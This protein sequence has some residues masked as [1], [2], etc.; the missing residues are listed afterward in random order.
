MKFSQLSRYFEKIEQT[1]SR[2]EITRLLA[3]LFNKLT[4][5]E[6]DKTIYLL[7][8]RVVPLFEKIDFG[9]AERLIIKSSISALNVDRKLFDKRF[10]KEGD[11]GRTVEKFKK[12]FPSL[13]ETDFTINEVYKN[14]YSLA[15][16]SG[17]GSQE[18]KVS[19]LADLI[20][21]TDPLSA[22]Y[23][24]RIPL[25][26]MRMGFSDM[27]V[28]D[29][30]SWMIT[31]DKTLRPKIQAAYHVR[32]DLGFIAAEIKKKGVA[33]LDKIVPKIFTPIIMMR[34]ERLS[35]GVEIV[36]KIGPCFIEPKYD[37]FRLQVHYKNDKV[38]LYS[39]SLEDVTFMYPDIVEAVKKE[40]RVNKVI[41]E[42]EAIGFDSKTCNFLPF[43]ETVQ[44]KR[45]FDIQKKA[46]EVPLKLFI[47]EILYLGKESYL[48]TFYEQRRKKLEEIISAKKDVKEKNII[49]APG[50]LVEDGARIE[51]LFDEA[52]GKGLEG[53][54]AKKLN[55]FYQ[56][57]ARGWSW[58]KFKHSY[59]SKVND[60]ID[61]LVMGYDL[62]RGKRTS[63]GI[64]AFLVG[65]YDE[66]KD[67]FLTMA[68]IGTG[69]TD[70]EWKQLK[71]KAQKL[72]V[73]SKPNNYLVNK[74]MECD[75]WINPGIVVEIRADEISK[76]PVHTTGFA[77][78]FPRLERFRNDKNPK[79]T[80]T[81]QEIEKMFKNQK[82]NQ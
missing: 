72:K 58:I 43:Q 9:I 20:R 51:E 39:R 24:V 62:G 37:G 21:R 7:Q 70:E 2:L 36:K 33:E 69:L 27:T 53:I 48:N 76:S 38:K 75:V 12:E 14:L 31:S 78:R 42:G 34:A 74:M 68:K 63:F 73:E 23:I 32:P 59:S 44:R 60:T 26:V 5:E 81:L 56:P 77:F 28:L 10:K 52:V 55:G 16:A 17:E 61:C 30:L 4:P 22:R 50:E 82:G 67:R 35:S 65:V 40:V 1:S 3:E 15:T 46:K 11:L 19:I 79:E 64:G 41:L 80:T 29:G 6:I 66:K 49:L 13:E 25:G 54:I 18:L 71:F 47:F 8:G 45:K 57:G